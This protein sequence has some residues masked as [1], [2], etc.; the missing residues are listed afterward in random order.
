M[1]ARMPFCMQRRDETKVKVQPKAADVELAP[2]PEGGGGGALCCDACDGT[3]RTEDCPVFKGKP[4]DKHRDAQKGKG[5]GIGGSGGNFVLKAARVV[6]QPGDGR[7]AAVVT[8][9]S[10]G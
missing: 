9:P 7:C 1:G 5:K 4:R 6:R 2:E 3:H 10:A 8:I